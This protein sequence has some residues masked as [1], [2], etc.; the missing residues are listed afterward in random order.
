LDKNYFQQYYRLERE[1][2]WFK[3]RQVILRKLIL[4]YISKE[5]QKLKILNV[6]TSTGYT[7]IWLSEFGEVKSVEYD[8]DCYEFVKE[9]IGI[10]IVNASIEDLPFEDNYFDL[11]CAFDVIEH[12]KNDQRGVNEMAR[13]C[14]DNGYIFVT[15]P[16]YQFLW[17]NH[18]VINHHQR[19][20]TSKK[21]KT[22]FSQND[23]IIF[24]SYFNMFLFP[25]IASFRLMSKLF[26]S[27]E[28]EV[29][30]DFSLSNQQG[31][32]ARIFYKIFSMESIFLKNNIIFP[33]GVSIGLIWKK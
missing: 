20:Y 29:S 24:T 11:V 13:V 6:G 30:S 18:D 32:V 23:A 12:V 3:A 28:K 14:K 26:K 1:H 7:S 31:V 25:I 8:K 5:S 9:N 22:L 2:W 16:A 15:V 33:F 10:D 19:R 17:S 21:L 27:S 4:K